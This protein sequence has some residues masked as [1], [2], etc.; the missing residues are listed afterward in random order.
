MRRWLLIPLL[1]LALGEGRRLCASEVLDGI[2][3]TVNSAAI[4]QSDIED[5]ARYEA[6]MEG[7]PPAAL[8]GAT[9]R[10]TLERLI[11]QEIVRQQ[12]A[13]NTPAPA[14][15][16]LSERLGQLRQQV[17]GAETLAGWTQALARYGLSEAEVQ[18][19]LRAQLQIARYIEQRLRPGIHVDGASVQAYYRDQLLP[20]LKRRGVA[21][22]PG[23][24]QV[25]QQIE[26]ILVQQ[27]LGQEMGSWVRSLREQARVRIGS[28][29][30]LPLSSARPPAEADGKPARGGK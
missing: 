4:L 16:E 1:L 18:D 25:W 7:R 13:G 22:A 9:R 5:A 21:A 15:T 14:A 29:L 30:L 23:L 12:I 10:A 27:K 17:P 2:A 28:D 20:E 3:A 24:R 19:R 11:D 8:D 6:L 26:E